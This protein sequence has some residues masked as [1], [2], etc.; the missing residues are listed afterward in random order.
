MPII[1][2]LVALVFL[3]PINRTGEVYM[4]A[5]FL[6]IGG[7]VLWGVNFLVTRRVGT[8]VPEAEVTTSPE[9]DRR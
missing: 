6:L 8:V 3:L 2:G 9:D 1:G 5:I 7:L 4:T